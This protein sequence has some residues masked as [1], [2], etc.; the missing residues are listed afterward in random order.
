MPASQLRKRIF[1]DRGTVALTNDRMAACVRH[2]PEPVEI[3]DQRGLVLRAAPDPIVV[4]DAQQHASTPIAR[5][6]PDVDGVDD[7]AEVQEA[8]WRRGEPGHNVQGSVK[9]EC[10]GR[11]VK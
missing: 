5:G 1:I 8:R 6:I 10:E 7:V 11:S 2:E 9:V 4:L 3:L